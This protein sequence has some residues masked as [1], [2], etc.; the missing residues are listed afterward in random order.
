MKDEQ[1]NMDDVSQ[2]SE[3]SSEKSQKK[4]GDAYE[5]ARVTEPE[6]KMR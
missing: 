6:E 4:M 2:E 1:N 3:S 5:M